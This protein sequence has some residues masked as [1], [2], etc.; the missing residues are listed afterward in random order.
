MPGH[1]ELFE[2]PH[3]E[4]GGGAAAHA[5]GLPPQGRPRHHR[6]EPRV[7]APDPGHVPGGQVE[8]ADPCRFRVPPPLRPR[9]PPPHLRRVPEAG[10]P[11]DLRLRD[12]GDVRAYQGQGPR[13]GADRPA[14]R[15]HGP[16]DRGEAREE[17]G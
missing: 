15:P 8:K 16:P 17:P 6:R 13:G 12:P 9:Q 3:R 7:H 10:Q 5:H 11:G 14:Y 1:R 2:A 4:E